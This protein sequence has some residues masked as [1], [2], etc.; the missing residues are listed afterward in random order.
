MASAKA[1]SAIRVEPARLILRT[2]SAR[3]GV[4]MN[5]PDPA[6]IERSA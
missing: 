2:A 4:G 6:N 5:S 1:A 3:S